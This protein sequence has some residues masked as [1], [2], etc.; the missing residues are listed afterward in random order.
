LRGVFG[1]QTS[2]VIVVFDAAHAPP[3]AVEIQDYHGIQVRFAVHH[4]QADDL[5]ELLIRQASAPRQ[6]TVVSD[7]H[8]VQKA[9]QRRHCRVL[10]CAAF[11]DWLESQRKAAKTPPADGAAKPQGV[12]RAETQHWLREFADLEHDPDFKEVFNPFD[13]EEDGEP[14]K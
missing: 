8:R 4:E 11:L 13:F 12:S 10:G 14:G 7:D 5:L 9:A 1:S 2:Q 3:G 6:L